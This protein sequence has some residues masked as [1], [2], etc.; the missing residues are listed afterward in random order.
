MVSLSNDDGRQG[1]FGGNNTN[2]Y[3]RG[4]QSYNQYPGGNNFGKGQVYMPGNEAIYHHSHPDV[5]DGMASLTSGFSGL[6][7]RQPSY[8]SKNNPQMAMAGIPTMPSPFMYNGLLYSQP[9]A[10][11]GLVSTTMSPTASMYGPMAS[12]YE[13]AMPPPYS[14]AYGGF[15]MMGSSAMSQGYSSRMP[16]GDVPSL[17]T[18]RRDS[19]SSNENDAPGTPLTFNGY[20]EFPNG[21]A[22]VD[23]SP[24]GS[25]YA[26]STPSPNGIGK[27]SPI[28]PEME[29]LLL[30]HPPIPRAI[31]APFSPSKPLDRSLENNNGVTNVYIRGLL[32]ETSDENLQDLARRFGEI[33]S[34]KSIIDHQTGLCKG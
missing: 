16:S 6:N 1:R 10:Q 8:P 34:S 13:G 25:L 31:P 20:S 33:Q 23:R 21:V 30:Q 24:L 26:Y 11:G 27:A 2:G 14:T 32:P 28:S 22:L 7:M 12:G 3:Q 19:P 5:V 15:P 4:G 9:G 18:P 29:K 17:V